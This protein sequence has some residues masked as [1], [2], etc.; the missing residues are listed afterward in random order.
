MA[1]KSDIRKAEAEAKRAE[2]EARRSEAEAEARKAE[3]NAALKRAE[4]EAAAKK[5][6]ADAA[7]RARKDKENREA[8]ARPYRTA[9]NLAAPFAGIGAGVALAKII[10]K[11]QNITVSARNVELAKLATEARKLNKVSR[12]ARVLE[13]ASIV[14]A[15]D[16]LHLGKV[17]GPLGV[18]TAGLLLVEGVYNRFFNAPSIDD[19]K[20]KAGAEA[21][22]TASAFAATTLLGERA[23]HNATPQ[24]LPA[25][26]DLAAIEKARAIAGGA[27]NTV[28][29]SLGR[30]VLSVAGKVATR[31]LF[32]VAAA[33]AAAAAF[34]RSAAAGE[35]RAESGVKAAAAAADSLAFGAIST[36]LGLLD[37]VP[38]PNARYGGR[39]VQGG[40][41]SG[42]PQSSPQG[43]AYL[44]E[45]AA[46]RQSA[47]PGEASSDAA[48][49][50]GSGSGRVYVPGY[51]RAGKS[52]A[53]YYRDR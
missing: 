24:A 36:G 45:A 50:P 40:V 16:N 6:E 17:T 48:A 3:A 31:V 33:A 28:V 14:K 25:A 29:P 18:A 49:R 34:S 12:S 26:K 41:V 30:R 47:P 42:P 53:S 10:E 37:A 35:G 7:E 1:R 43:R 8:D 38:T 9:A 32:P 23:L 15:A 46:A 22:G 51:T 20:T 13:A 11:R 44:N 27:A 5:A 21:L 39:I 19:E 2:A 4:A 52:V